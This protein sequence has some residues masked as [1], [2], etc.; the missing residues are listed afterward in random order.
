MDIKIVHCFCSE[1][2]NSTHLCDDCF[3]MNNFTIQFPFS[4]MICIFCILLI[5]ILIFSHKS[6]GK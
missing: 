1:A 4:L 2:I 6:Q 5:Y 3:S